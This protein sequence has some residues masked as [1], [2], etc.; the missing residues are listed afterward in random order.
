MSAGRRSISPASGAVRNWM[1]FRTDERGRSPTS[2]TCNNAHRPS[3]SPGDRASPLVGPMSTGIIVASVRPRARSALR[4]SLDRH[5]VAH[6]PIG[7]TGALTF[8]DCVTFEHVIYPKQNPLYNVEKPLRVFEQSSDNPQFRRG[9]KLGQ[10]RCLRDACELR[11]EVL[12]DL[13]QDVRFRPIFMWID[14]TVRILGPK[15]DGAGCTI[16]S[17]SMSRGACLRA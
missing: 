16:K 9:T 10:A 13:G 14:D 15:R 6:D 2:K 4:E 11:V 5:P 12:R 17:E 8:G 7:R 1:F 3:L